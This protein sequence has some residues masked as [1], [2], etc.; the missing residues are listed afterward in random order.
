MSRKG[1]ALFAAV[2]VIWGIPFLLI[3]VAD[4]GGLSVAV[5]VFARVFIGALVLLPAA[6]R[7]GTLKQL[8]PRWRWV[9]ALS[10]VEVILPWA[11][12]SAAEQHLSSSLSGLI[13]AATPI[14]GVGVARLAG[15]R[16]RLTVTRVAGLAIGLGGVTALLGPAVAGGSTIAVAEAFGTAVCYAI[17]PVIAARKL[18]GTDSLSLTAA[19]LTLAS[20]VYVTPAML[21]LPRHLPSTNVLASLAGLAVGCTA[22]AFLLYLAL[23]AEVGPVRA[24]VVTYVNPAV[25]VVLGVAVLGEPLTPR[26]LAAFALI[27]VGS[28]LAT[29]TRRVEQDGGVDQRQVGLALRDVAEECA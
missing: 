4:N 11:L 23:I 1:W 29:T 17:G 14:V 8:K 12:L 24:E 6:I 28:V 27:L 13:L 3:K 21:T 18:A 19:S 10:V 15:D 26:M 9:V 5:L 7:R 2:G 20:L 16:D 25:A 22:L